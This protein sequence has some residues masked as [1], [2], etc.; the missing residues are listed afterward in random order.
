M[1]LD[2]SA[3][4]Q[5]FSDLFS[6][7]A[8]PFCWPVSLVSCDPGDEG[9]EKNREW[10]QT[11]KIALKRR[12]QKKGGKATGAGITLFQ[13]GRIALV[14]IWEV[15]KHEDCECGKRENPPVCHRE[16]M[17]MHNKFLGQVC[18]LTILL[19]VYFWK[20]KVIYGCY[21][22]FVFTHQP[23]WNEIFHSLCSV[24]VV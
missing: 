13:V 6:R 2:L 10:G 15:K 7:P 14:P 5:I 19:L 16:S 11:T 18:L 22:R 1:F 12:Q 23:A 21:M 24:L 4:F 8:R 9:G 3:E 20:H 17:K